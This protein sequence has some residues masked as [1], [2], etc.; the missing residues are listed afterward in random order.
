MPELLSDVTHRLET[1]R[2]LKAIEADLK[3]L[4]IR[5]RPAD[6]LFKALAVMLVHDAKERAQACELPILETLKASYGEDEKIRTVLAR[7]VTKAA[8]IPADTTTSG[9]ADSLVQTVIGDFIESLMPTSVYAQLAA[10]GGSFTFGRNGAVMLPARNTANT[11]AGS[12]VAQG[13]PIPVR[14]GAFTPITLT[15]KKMAVI[16]A[17]TREITEHSTPSIEAII[18]QAIMDD[19]AVAID[20]VLLDANAAT[21][22]RPAGLKN[23]VSKTTPTAGGAVAAAV[24]GDIRALATSLING[25]SGNL[26]SLVWIMNRSTCS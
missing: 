11:V 26:R 21:T 2:R 5:A 10:L 1:S 3:G 25:A 4:C 24:I 23:G 18:R 12:F 7:M 15:P 17:L 22:T 9:W 8:V 14:Q 6:T 19:T 16:V 13:A 20:T